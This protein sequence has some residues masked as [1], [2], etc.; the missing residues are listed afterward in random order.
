MNVMKYF[1]S[2]MS[3]ALA[4]NSIAGIIC[5]QVGESGT[6]SLSCPSGQVMISIDFASYGLP[7][8]AC[9]NFAAQSSC[10]AGT[11]LNVVKAACATGK[12]T[13]SVKASNSV[14]ADPCVGKRKKLFVQVSCAATSTAASAVP[15]SNVSVPPPIKV[16]VNKLALPSIV[17]GVVALQCGQVYGGTLDL[18]SKSNVTVKV[19]GNCG[20]PTIVPNAGATAIVAPRST[21]ITISGIKIQG[22]AR[23][24]NVNDADHITISNVDILKSGDAGIYCS[25]VDVMKVSDSTFSDSGKTG[26]DCGSWVTNSSVKNSTFLSAGAAGGNYTGIGIYFGDGSGNTVDHNTVSNTVYHGIVVLH[27]SNTIASANLV[28]STCTGADKDC[29]AIYTGDRTKDNL[30]L[31]ISGNKVVNNSAIGIYLDDFS[32][33]VIVTGNEIGNSSQAMVLHNGFNNI[34]KNNNFYASAVRHIA[35]AQDFDNAVYGNQVTYNTFTA[36]KGELA[37]SFETGQ[38][39]KTFA[40]FDYNTYSGNASNFARFWT[41]GNNAGFNKTFTEWKSYVN[42]DAHSKMK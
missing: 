12:S 16:P 25:G 41:G 3:F 24:I 20:K 42:Q 10:H 18:T 2:I 29:G 33:G 21:Y 30:Q 23:G 1:I 15:G 13:C 7:T 34:I 4:Q 38:N 19:N 40:V 31:T 14:F 32:S 17:N 26:I 28:S 36:T 5:S 8:G 39:L 37:F 11:S 22:G 27:N 6:S 35:F 9:G